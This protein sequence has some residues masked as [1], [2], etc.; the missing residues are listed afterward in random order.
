MM[1]GYGKKHSI[2]FKAIAI[3]LVCLFSVNSISLAQTATYNPSDATL[4][5]QSIFRPILDT[6]GTSYST[7][8]E[9]EMA[10]II[11]TALRD[12][13][14]PG[15]VTSRLN[16]NSAL[17]Q[18]SNF[19]LDMRYRKFLEVKTNPVMLDDKNKSKVWYIE[20][21]RARKKNIFRVVFTGSSV[22]D[23][24][25]VSKIGIIPEDEIQGVHEK[26]PIPSTGKPV[27]DTNLA[28]ADRAIKDILHKEFGIDK[29]TGGALSRSISGSFEDLSDRDKR[30]VNREIALAVI[31]ALEGDK[32]EVER[33]KI[34]SENLLSK[35]LIAGVNH[36][37][38]FDIGIEW[39]TN[40][41]G[42]LEL[43]G[44]SADAGGGQTNVAKVFKNFGENFGLVAIS[45][46]HDGAINRRWV[47]DLSGESIVSFF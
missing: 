35:T 4:A 24:L 29:L 19:G 10:F 27:S 9:A 39:R 25:D 3:G 38:P 14:Q 6:V 47:N 23:M 41:K 44:L 34:V 30:R 31:K 37:G 13:K 1:I 42:E 20:T 21:T 18:Q 16:I 26:S 40:D 45:G 11:G 2:W 12:L 7:R 15:D 17:D 32:G 22:A 28:Q 46:K 36:S 43:V 5:A 8:I 33:G